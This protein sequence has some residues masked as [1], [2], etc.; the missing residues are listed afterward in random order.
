M[1]RLRSPDDASV[2]VRGNGRVKS[3]RSDGIGMASVGRMVLPGMT[4]IE[5]KRGARPRS[6]TPLT[7]S[8]HCWAIS[9]RRN[10][11]ERLSTTGAPARHGDSTVDGARTLAGFVGTASRTKRR[12]RCAG[13]VGV[14][15]HA[16]R[17]QH[18]APPTV[19]RP[20]SIVWPLR[21]VPRPSAAEPFHGFPRAADGGSPC[22]PATLVR[23]AACTPAANA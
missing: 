18:V 13:R 6:M 9:S 22:R 5:C 20:M 10:S 17:A 8:L 16:W 2:F 21:L 11:I 1:T 7:A 19:L 12:L 15:R 23:A 14:S 4:T 3:R